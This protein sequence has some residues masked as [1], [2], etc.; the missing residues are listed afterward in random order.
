MKH[1]ATV[2]A[3]LLVAFA[4]V[5]IPALPVPKDGGVADALRSATAA[6]R[7]AIASVYR[8]LGDITKR[9][10]GKQIKTTG[11]WRSV[12]ASVLRLAF[13]GTPLVGKYPGLDIAVDKVFTASVPLDNVALTPEIITSL[14][15]GCQKVAAASGGR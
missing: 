15:A 11:V 8:S 6:D 12:H 2:I 10:A 14:S 1:L 3:G 9:D 5:R 13:G 7:D 4:F